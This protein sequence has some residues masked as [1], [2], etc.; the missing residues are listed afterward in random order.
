MGRD[1]EIHE[2]L[3]L[4]DVYLEAAKL[5]IENDLLEPALFNAIH[6]LEL[7]IKATLMIRIQGPIITH[8]VGGLLGRY[9][10]DVLGDKKCRNI[11]SI[12]IRY[13][14]PRYPA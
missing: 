12:L 3:D 6:A 7:S 13:N 1:E 8:N 10:R 11:N 5:N 4:S 9:Y 2:H 14:L